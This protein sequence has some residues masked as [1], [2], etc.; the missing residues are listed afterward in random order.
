MIPVNRSPAW[1]ALCRSLLPPQ[2][3]ELDVIYTKLKLGMKSWKF[4]PA[5]ADLGV[6]IMSACRNPSLLMAQ[7]TTTKLKLWKRSNI[8]GVT[9][10]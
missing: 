2:Q 4:L 3:L 10:D 9:D 6:L 7:F 5:V 1:Q 8:L